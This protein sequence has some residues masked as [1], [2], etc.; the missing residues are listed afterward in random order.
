MAIDYFASNTI[1][2]I[3]AYPNPTKGLLYIKSISEIDD[4]ELSFYAMDGKNIRPTY[5]KIG[6]TEWEI[7]ME[8]YAIG[9]YFIIAHDKNSNQFNYIKVIKK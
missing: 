6:A 3:V 1:S 8:N 4:L 9:T 5:K 2:E 7:D